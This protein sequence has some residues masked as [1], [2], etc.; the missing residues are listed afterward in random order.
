MDNKE[1][2]NIRFMKVLAYAL[3]ATA[4]TLHYGCNGFVKYIMFNSSPPQQ[5]G[6]HF[7]DDNFRCILVNK[8]FCIF[9]KI[10]LKF[11]PKGPIDNN[12]ALI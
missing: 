4:D 11:V 8:K 12:Q 3:N 7:P 6:R 5:N 10:S 1:A 2:A 9:I